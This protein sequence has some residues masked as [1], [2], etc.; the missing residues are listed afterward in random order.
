MKKRKLFFTSSI[1]SLFL[2]LF[3]FGNVVYA[4]SI[5]Y[6]SKN[7]PNQYDIQLYPVLN[8]IDYSTNLS[9]GKNAWNSSAARV[10]FNTY[11]TPTRAPYVKVTDFYFGNT[12]WHAMA[13]CYTAAN[14]SP[15]IQINDSY[16]PFG[17]NGAELIAHELGH[18]LRLDD[19]SDSTSLMLSA[20]YKGNPT[21]AQD[22]VNGV[23]SV[24]P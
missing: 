10:Y 11:S 24:Y 18:I 5:I 16:Y 3:S 23:N 1:L 20:G 14:V 19:I 17:G 2:F 9:I 15:N 22:D 4:Y 12:Q 13:Y 21:P 6:G 8:N 7:M